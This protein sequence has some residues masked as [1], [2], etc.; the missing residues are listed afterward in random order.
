M[1]IFDEGMLVREVYGSNKKVG[2]EQIITDFAG[3][4]E[5]KEKDI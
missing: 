1:E 4:P 2:W 5:D 3:K